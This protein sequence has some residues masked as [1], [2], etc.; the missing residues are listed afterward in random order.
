VEGKESGGFLI[1]EDPKKS[2]SAAKGDRGDGL[3]KERSRTVGKKVASDRLVRG[4]RET[5]L[6]GRSRHE[7][8][9]QESRKNELRPGKGF[10]KGK[11]G[12]GEMQ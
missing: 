2:H 10:R 6:V 7:A 8:R 4:K 11:S 1:R 5:E 9:G 3:K 12:R